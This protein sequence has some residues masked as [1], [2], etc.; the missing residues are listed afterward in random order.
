M[1]RLICVVTLMSA[2]I[3]GIHAQQEVSRISDVVYDHKDGLAFVFDVIK[4]EKQTRL[5]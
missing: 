2:L 3:V 5:K 1:K 4:P